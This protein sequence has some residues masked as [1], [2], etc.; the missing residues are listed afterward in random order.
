MVTLLR[1]SFSLTQAERADVL[2]NSKASYCTAEG[3]GSIA[4]STPET[5]LKEVLSADSRFGVNWQEISPSPPQRP[6]G[7]TDSSRIQSDA[8]R[9]AIGIVAVSNYSARS[10]S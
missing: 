8:Q 10:P 7:I 2:P 9:N 3:G 4:E 5:S 1:L 6:F